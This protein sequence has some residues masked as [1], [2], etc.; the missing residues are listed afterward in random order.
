VNVLDEID[1]VFQLA[2]DT[3]VKV[4][5]GLNGDYTRATELLLAGS[6]QVVVT[7]MGKSRLIAQKIAAAIVSSGMPAIFLHRLPR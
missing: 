3:L 6:G 4:R 2:I 5:Q 7:G 1:R